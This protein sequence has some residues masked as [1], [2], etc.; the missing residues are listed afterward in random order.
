MSLHQN[1]HFQL[2]ISC[3]TIFDRKKWIIS[4]AQSADPSSLYKSPTH[5]TSE[6]ELHQLRGLRPITRDDSGFYPDTSPPQRGKIRMYSKTYHVQSTN[7]NLS[8]YKSH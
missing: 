4:F 5:T 8:Y 6:A 7:V 1:Y 2:I 3:N